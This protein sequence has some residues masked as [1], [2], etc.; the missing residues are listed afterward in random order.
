MLDHGDRSLQAH[1]AAE[2]AA[3]QGKFWAM[4]DIIFENQS[5]LYGGNIQ[6][7]LKGLAEQVGLDSQQFGACLDEQR[8]AELV[9]GQDDFRRAQGVRTR[10]TFDINGQLIVGAQGFTAFQSI[11]DAQL[12]Q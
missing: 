11:I 6:E 12:A 3:E 9:Q 1:Q 4:H 2:C 8:Y 5:D 10:P 7:S